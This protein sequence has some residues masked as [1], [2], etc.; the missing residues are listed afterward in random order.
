MIE[1]AEYATGDSIFSRCCVQGKVGANFLKFYCVNKASSSWLGLP[2]YS[3]FGGS[4]QVAG[5]QNK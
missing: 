3:L 1:V 4:G 5:C 2:V